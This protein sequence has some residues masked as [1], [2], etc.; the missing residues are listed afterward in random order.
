M[1]TGNVNGVE[2]LIG[3][4]ATERSVLG[5]RGDEGR[6]CKGNKGWMVIA[7]MSGGEKATSVCA[8]DIFLL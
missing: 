7:H 5:F 8:R 4:A 2:L 1:E 3:A 6:D